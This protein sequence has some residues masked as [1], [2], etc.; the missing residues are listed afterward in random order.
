[1]FTPTCGEVSGARSNKQGD[2]HRDQS[3]LDLVL[4]TIFR[5]GAEP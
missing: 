2:L 4:K 1:M 3:G 5:A